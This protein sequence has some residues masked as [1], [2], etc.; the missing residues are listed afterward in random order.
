MKEKF[1]KTIL[2]LRL[3]EALNL[4]DMKQSELADKTGVTR[5]L[6]NQYLSGYTL[7]KN[8]KIF[9]MAKALHVQEAW[10]MGFDVPMEK[11]E[12]SDVTITFRSDED[13]E[14]YKV[15]I[16]IMEKPESRKQLEVYAKFL[17]SQI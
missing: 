4:R 12:K 16:E 13:K 5:G 11:D 14:M 6:I 3:R 7:P 17:Y 2:P 1:D 9:L 10:L 15:L 8:D